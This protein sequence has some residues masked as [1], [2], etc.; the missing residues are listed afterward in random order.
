LF[1]GD[2]EELL[3]IEFAALPETGRSSVLEWRR[4]Y[5]LTLA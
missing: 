1:G 4:H 2:K 3:K 5:G